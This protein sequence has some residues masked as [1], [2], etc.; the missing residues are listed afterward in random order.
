MNTELPDCSKC[1]KPKKMQKSSGKQ[2]HQHSRNKEEQ[3]IDLDPAKAWIKNMGAGTTKQMTKLKN[4]KRDTLLATDTI[5]LST[6]T[7]SAAANTTKNESATASQ[8]N[9][10]QFGLDHAMDEGKF[11]ATLKAMAMDIT[12]LSI[13]KVNG[14]DNGE[15]SEQSGTIGNATYDNDATN[16][17][18]CIELDTTL[19]NS[20]V[21]EM[22][23][24]KPTCPTPVQSQTMDFKPTKTFKPLPLELNT[25]LEDETSLYEPMGTMERMAERM[26]DPEKFAQ[27]VSQMKREYN[28]HFDDTMVHESY[29]YGLDTTVKPSRAHEL[30]VPLGSFD[31]LSSTSSSSLLSPSNLSDI[32]PALSSLTL[33]STA[34]PTNKRKSYFNLELSIVFCCSMKF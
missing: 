3:P 26:K 6:T 27:H 2:Q 21:A 32:K 25:V 4:V 16:Y 5:I 23:D 12:T 17:Q 10:M 13:Q 22:T 24:Y 14:M 33:D 31:F 28:D 20:S 30:S 18:T 15:S 19:M 29:P 8:T 7:T 9:G 34:L 1:L 11:N